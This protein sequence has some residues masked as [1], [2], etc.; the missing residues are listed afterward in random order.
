MTQALYDRLDPTQTLARDLKAAYDVK[1]A[2]AK[3][4]WATF[5]RERRKAIESGADLTKDASKLKELEELHAAYNA[6]A[7]EAEDLR[8]RLDKH[9]LGVP[10]PSG[11]AGDTPGALFAK[12]LA[13][14]GIDF[15]AV[16]TGG[17]IVPAT[18]DTLIRALP[19]RQL[20]LRNL[21]TVDQA[22]ADTVS[23][24]RQ[25]VLTNAAAPVAAGALKP[26]S[27]ITVERVD[28]SVTTIAHLTEPVDRALL[29]DA[30]ELA[31]FIDQ[32]LILGV[33]LAEENQIVNGSGTAP[34]LRGVLN[35]T[36]V[37]T[38]ARG[39]DPAI[40]AILKGITQVRGNFFEPTAILMHP[41]D[42]MNARLAKNASGDYYFGDP[43]QDGDA[44]IFGLPVA[45]SPVL[46]AGTAIVADWTQATLWLREDARVTFAEAGGLGTAGVEIFSRNQIVFRGEERLAFGVV[47]PAAFCSVTGL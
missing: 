41:T 23:Y 15:K 31:E 9:L 13:A 32:Q 29:S 1:T 3:D 4:L 33:L 21:V 14:Q 40:E 26:T 39:T 27:T 20:R 12:N 35:T 18:F 47:R 22:D 7:A 38:Q 30:D 5:D 17:S 25:S 6:V 28:S 36:G 11:A 24:L 37:L 8:D 19:Q 34:N 10:T 46:A 42:F 16:T 43:N 45:I 44:S 2:E